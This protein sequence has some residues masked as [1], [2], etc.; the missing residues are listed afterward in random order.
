[1]TCRWLQRR[2]HI[3]AGIF[4]HF[5]DS[6]CGLSGIPFGNRRR[7][8]EGTTSSLSKKGMAP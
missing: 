6:A 7:A 5:F 8:K 3:S 4:G 1:M 2:R